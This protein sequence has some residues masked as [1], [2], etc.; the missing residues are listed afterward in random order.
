MSP[1]SFWLHYSINSCFTLLYT[2]CL[3]SP[4]WLC[5]SNIPLITSNLNLTF[6]NLLCTSHFTLQPWT[7]RTSVF[8]TL[9]AQFHLGTFLQIWGHVIWGWCCSTVHKL[10]PTFPFWYA[11]STS[12]LLEQLQTPKYPSSK[13]SRQLVTT[14]GTTTPGIAG[15][16]WCL[17]R[18]ESMPVGS[19]YPYL[20]LVSQRS[21]KLIFR[22]FQP[23]NTILINCPHWD[24]SIWL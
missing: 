8:G 17:P 19:S 14:I 21:L 6:L 22:V 3:A 13:Q 23:P 15:N 10:K 11:S 24:T 20:P 9:L 7:P 18:V 12:G 16:P 4:A 1:S 2:P 5:D